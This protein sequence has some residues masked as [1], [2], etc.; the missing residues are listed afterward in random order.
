MTVDQDVWD[1]VF[2]YRDVERPAQVAVDRFLAEH[3]R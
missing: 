2:L 3:R 1:D